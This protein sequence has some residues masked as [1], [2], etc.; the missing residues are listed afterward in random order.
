MYE[1]HLRVR[2]TPV[3]FFNVYLLLR[4]LNRWKIKIHDRAWI[5]K[6]LRSRAALESDDN[7]TR[8]HIGTYFS[9]NSTSSRVCT[10]D[11]CGTRVARAFS[12]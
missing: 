2:L 5:E 3:H 11:S 1:F 12:L 8:T 6:P 7:V 9:I 10:L 4:K